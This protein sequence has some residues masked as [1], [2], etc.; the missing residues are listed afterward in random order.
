M[1]S[2]KVRDL[3]EILYCMFYD[4]SFFLGKTI[5]LISRRKGFILTVNHYKSEGALEEG[6]DLILD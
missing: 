1:F 6:E 4:V 2:V 5:S 3:I